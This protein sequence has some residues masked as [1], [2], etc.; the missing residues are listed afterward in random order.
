M[1][2]ANVTPGHIPLIALVGPTASGKTALALAL[3]ERLP[4]ALGLR[5]AEIVSADS[6]QIYRLM[7]IATAKPTAEERASI[8]HHLLDASN[9]HMMRRQHG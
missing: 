5:G 9:H 3:A 4:A 7:D 2:H 1:T 6:R 8:P